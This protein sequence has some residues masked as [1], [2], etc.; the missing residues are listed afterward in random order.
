MSCE[1]KSYK[2][3][4]NHLD[5]HIE[6]LE[7]QLSHT[8]QELDELYNIVENTPNNMELGKRV[9]QYYMENTE[10]IS[11]ESIVDRNQNWA[12]SYND[13]NEEELN[14]PTN[15]QGFETSRSDEWRVE[16]FN[17][18]REPEEWVNNVDQMDDAVD[19][20][21]PKA[22]IEERIK[23]LEQELQH[24]GYHDGYTLEGMRAELKSLKSQESEDNRQLSLFDNE[25]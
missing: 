24:D 16:Q 10:P 23:Y 15:N 22:D 5:S 19:E 20:L 2:H 13:V 3:H 4:L 6:D 25:Q 21:F 14:K 11:D 17:R 12:S 9:R 7:N 1:E 8:N 18:N